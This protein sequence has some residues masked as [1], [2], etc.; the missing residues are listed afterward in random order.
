M[1]RLKQ[2]FNEHKPDHKDKHKNT[3]LIAL[4]LRTLRIYLQLWQYHNL[5]HLLGTLYIYENEKNPKRNSNCR[6]CR[7]FLLVWW[8]TCLFRVKRDFLKVLTSFS[9]FLFP[10]IAVQRRGRWV[11]PCFK[12][13]DE[14][15]KPSNRDHRET[16]AGDTSESSQTMGVSFGLD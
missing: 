1:L 16:Q 15:A 3:S 7:H 9:S 12:W 14:H 13:R 2:N 6:D 5:T 10:A 4:I 8:K 11:N